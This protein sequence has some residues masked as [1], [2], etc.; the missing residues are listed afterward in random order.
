MRGGETLA[1]A[2]VTLAHTDAAGRPTRLPAS[3]RAALASIAA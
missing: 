3:L 2:D 1:E